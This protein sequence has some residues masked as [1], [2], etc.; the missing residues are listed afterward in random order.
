[1]SRQFYCMERKF[2]ELRKP[3]SRKYKCLLTVVYTKYFTSVGQT[4]SATTYYGREQIRFQLEEE[5]RKKRWKWIGYILGKAPN[6]TQRQAV[7]WNH[8]GQKRS[9]RPK[10][11]LHR[12][13]EI[14]VRRMNNSTIDLE[15]RAQDRVCW[16]MLVCGLCSIRSN[17]RK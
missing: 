10:S 4:P 15:K 6:C 12:E 5:I 8:Q 9:G 17:R 16:R 13:M 1:M 14:D 7:T 2:G 3:S 11:T